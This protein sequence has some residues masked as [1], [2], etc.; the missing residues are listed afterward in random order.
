MP[1]CADHR[2]MLA[3]GMRYSFHRWSF[4]WSAWTKHSSPHT[5]TLKEIA[6]LS[7][8]ADL[9]KCETFWHLARSTSL[10]PTSC[11]GF[12]A[13]VQA[14]SLE[15]VAKQNSC[16]IGAGVQNNLWWTPQGLAAFQHIASFAYT[17]KDMKHR[18]VSALTECPETAHPYHL[19]HRIIEK[20]TALEHCFT[21]S[22]ILEKKCCNCTVSAL[23]RSRRDPPA[24]LTQDKSLM[25]MSGPLK[26][27]HWQVGHP[28][29]QS[30]LPT[31]D[32][33]DFL[34]YSYLA[35]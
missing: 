10:Q 15:Q 6:H 29:T 17:K 4:G 26:V 24:S 1:I 21:A 18:W 3:F 7:W 33:L 25:I 2:S 5:L 14:H 20:R 34:K 9:E 16:L 11:C 27:W 22:A 23:R 13:I 19:D 12:P 30:A 32:I 8:W 28:I 35:T 31:E